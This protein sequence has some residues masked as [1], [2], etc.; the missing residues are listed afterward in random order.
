MAIKKGA[1]RAK[2]VLTRAEYDRK[3]EAIAVASGSRFGRG[4]VALKT[5]YML[6]PSRFESE[7]AEMLTKAGIKFK[8]N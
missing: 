2:G 5:G 7:R 4:N 3:V 8:K 6:T 1:V